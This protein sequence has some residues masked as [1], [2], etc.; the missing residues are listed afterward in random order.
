MMSYFSIIFLVAL[1]ILPARS[2]VFASGN[3]EN[4]KVCLYKVILGECKPPTDIKVFPEKIR[5]RVKIYLDRRTRFRSQLNLPKPSKQD[6]DYFIR[7]VGYEKKEELER[8]MVSLV[9]RKG[10]ES[11]AADYAHH[12]ILFYEW[13]GFSDGPLAEAQYAENYLDKNPETPLE[14]YLILFLTHRYRIV[15]E[16]LGYENKTQEQ[17]KASLKYRLY[18]KKAKEHEDPLVRVA[19]QEIDQE[20]YLYINTRSHP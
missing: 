12:A 9:G 3:N 14:P 5:S 15:F 19:G 17:E 7:K 1:I 4:T 2:F 20:P 13:E 11:V 16:C 10:I 8:G 18:L 6:R